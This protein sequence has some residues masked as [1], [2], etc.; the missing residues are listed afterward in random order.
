MAYVHSLRAMFQFG[1]QGF[2]WWR[3]CVRL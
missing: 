2:Q 1:Y 3:S